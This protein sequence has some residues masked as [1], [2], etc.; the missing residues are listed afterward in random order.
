MI[1]ALAG[2][3]GGSKLVL[4]LARVLPP[5]DLTVIVNTGDDEDF[6]GLR[7]C[8]DLDTVLYTLGSLVDPE[9]GWGLAEERFDTLEMLQRY[10]A[11]TWFRLGNKDL[12]THLLRSLW[13]REG[14]RLTEVTGRFAAALG[15]ATRILPMA[16]APVATRLMIAADDGAG[17]RELAFQEYFVQRRWRDRVVAV[18]FA[19]IEQT[20]ISREALEAIAAA[21]AII[22]CPSNPVVSIEPILSVPGMRQAIRSARCPRVA[23][24]PIIGGE[25][26]SGPAARL[27][28]D[29][30]R[31]PTAVGVARL[32]A[33]VLSHFILDTRDAAQR[34]AVEKL[35]LQAGVLNTLMSSQEEKETL[36]RALLRRIGV[37]R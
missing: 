4:G 2:G 13:L 16:D 11:A 30:G 36:A 1:V 18:R 14:L 29:L 8:P 19:G 6:Y 20:A 35:G 9:Q 7:V 5:G 3:V 24:S 34:P 12:A 27:M 31:E 21:K 28:A 26:V 15:V 22:F 23:L 33:D 32:Y 37:E 10:G 17:E 25:A